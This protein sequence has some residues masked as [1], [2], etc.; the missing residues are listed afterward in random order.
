MIKVALVGIGAMGFVHYKAYKELE[1]ASVIAVADLRTDMAKEKIGEDKV[2][3][4]TSFDEMLKNENP[5]M[6]DICL[7]SY[8]HKEY[9]LKALEAGK[10][11]LCEKPM[12]LNSEDS[13][14]MI[15][16]AKKANKHLMIAHVVRFMS[17]YVYLRETI[18]SKRF[19][20]P[21]KIDMKRLSTIPR[22]SWEN[23]MRDTNKSG[24][25]P[26]D[27][28]IHDIDYIQ[29]IFG[30]PKDVRGTY[31]KLNADNDYINSELIY[32]GFTVSV[33][34]GWFNTDI[35]FRA[36]F[37]AI[38]ENGYLEYKNNIMIENGKEIEI[39]LGKTSDDTGINLS[40]ADGYADEIAYFVDC[41][42]NDR[43]PLKVTPE[44]SRSSV[45]LIERI[46]D[47]SVNI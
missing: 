28:S 25:T 37:I 31:H 14:Q 41:I 40:G 5:D 44:S 12:S 23:W 9:T 3:L 36:E 7:P 35:S 16:A 18:E 11:V 19:G 47:N 26:I 8:L 13:A 46:L 24:G 22:W 17:P 45:G 27:L 20:N 15:E 2:N 1:N 4:Y 6:I 21:I 33:L 42:L 38:F 30:E 43:S 34:G 10:H 39:K 32:D 29:S